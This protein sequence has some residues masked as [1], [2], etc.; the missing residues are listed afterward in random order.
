MGRSASCDLIT[1]RAHVAKDW[2]RLQFA[3]KEA[4]GDRKTVAL[5]VKQDGEALEFA[6]E[7]LKADRSPVLSAVA[8]HGL[9]LRFADA[10]AQKAL[11]DW[12]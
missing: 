12:V 2:R 5:A 6:S 7:K 8:T 3:P 1:W 10:E 4:R 11:H 9:A